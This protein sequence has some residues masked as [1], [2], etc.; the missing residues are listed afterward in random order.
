MSGR[1]PYRLAALFFGD[2]FALWRFRFFPSLFFYRRP[3]SPFCYVFFCLSD[4]GGNG[5]FHL[6]E[7]VL[8]R[9]AAVWKGKDCKYG[10]T[11]V[12]DFVLGSMER[13]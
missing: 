8:E 7:K 6:I 1:P 2:V 3:L 11:V 12:L 5:L 4:T 9:C 10:I 13:G